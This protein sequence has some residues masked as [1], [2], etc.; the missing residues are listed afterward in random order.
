MAISLAKKYG[1]EVISCDSR[2]FYREIPVGTAAPTLSEQDGVPHHFIGSHSLREEYSAGR[3]SQDALR[4]LEEKFKEH[5]IMFMT[6]GSGLYIDAVCDGMDDIPQVAEEVRTALQEKFLN[7]GLEPLRAQLQELDPVFFETVDINNPQR[8]I[9]ALEVCVQTGVPYSTLRTGK[10]VDRPFNVIKIGL[11]M[12]RK[13]LY[14]RINRRVDMMLE[15]GLE[16]EARSVYPLKEVN[17]LQTV[18]YKEFFAYFDG[19]ISREDAIELIKR[20]SRRYA[21]RQETWFGRDNS[22]QWFDAGEK[23]SSAISGTLEGFV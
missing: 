11:R 1:S 17:A 19:K 9:R 20:N 13:V 23:S 10:R 18:G 2:Q 4:L 14:D 16:Q 7:E 5:D 15:Q 21:K 22:I 12:P 8:I 3:F 6:G